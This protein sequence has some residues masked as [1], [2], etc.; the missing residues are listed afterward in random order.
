ML[1]WRWSLE[2]SIKHD[3]KFLKGW[4]FMRL[5]L[6]EKASGF[7]YDLTSGLLKPVDA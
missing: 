3:V 1:I 5:E 2:L 4:K 7:I 6:A